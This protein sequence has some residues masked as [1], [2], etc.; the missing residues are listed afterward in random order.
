[1]ELE[2]QVVFP[3]LSRRRGQV[4]VVEARF[5][6]AG[7]LSPTISE[8]KSS[9]GKQS[10]LLFGYLVGELHKRSSDMALDTLE[11]GLA[12]WQSLKTK[13]LFLFSRSSLLSIYIALFQ[14]SQT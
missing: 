6:Y 5:Y 8:G 11:S 10:N 7:L 13:N 3:G 9:V 4:G 2:S 14:Q 1:V 12:T